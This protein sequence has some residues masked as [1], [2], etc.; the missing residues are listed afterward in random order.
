MAPQNM[1]LADRVM[2]PGNQG[3]GRR[4]S[5]GHLDGAYVLE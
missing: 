5:L 2:S 4:D 3:P 1:T